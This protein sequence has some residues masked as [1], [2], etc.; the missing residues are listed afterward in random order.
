MTIKELAD[1]AGVSTETITRCA[2]ELFPDHLKNGVRTVF[3]KDQAYDVMAIV[4]K[5]NLVS[6]LQTEKV[7]LQ[8]E[9]VD[10][11]VIGEMIGLAVKSALEP[12]VSQMAERKSTQ[13]QIE[14]NSVSHM[15]VSGYSKVEGLGLSES[16]MKSHG[17]SLSKL[18][19]ERHL[20]TQSVPHSRYGRINSYPMDL[21]EE[22]FRS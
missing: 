20:E 12:L 14:D 17:A 6:P 11:R 3:T 5:K 7:P 19:R 22:Y 2:N 9:K 4:R 15:T 1:V 21:L 13:L 8:T 16:E 10:Y 18:C